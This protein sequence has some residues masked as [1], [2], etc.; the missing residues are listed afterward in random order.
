MTNCVFC[1][2]D[3]DEE[4]AARIDIDIGTVGDTKEKLG[5]SFDISVEGAPLCL[6]HADKLYEG[7]AD[8]E[9]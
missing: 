6:A 5:D 9:Y 1:T 7:L 2:I 4:P 8:Y 3:G